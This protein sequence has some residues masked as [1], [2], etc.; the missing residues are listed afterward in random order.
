MR[1]E[2][3]LPYQ[4]SRLAS[5]KQRLARLIGVPG[6]LFAQPAQCLEDRERR[7]A[8]VARTRLGR[9]LRRES[10]SSPQ[11]RIDRTD[12]GRPRPAPLL[13]AEIDDAL[14]M[15]ADVPFEE[16]QERGWHVQPNSYLWP[17]NDVPFLRRNPELWAPPRIPRGIEWDLDGQ[18]DLLRHLSHYAD[19]LADVRDGPA[20]RPG[21]FVWENGAFGTGDALAYY[22][23]V[24]D[25]KPKRV[26]EIGAG[27]STLLLA[28]AWRRTAVMRR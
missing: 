20:H 21:E 2:R 7:A 25:L 23:L 3:S 26:I 8:R 28:R 17:L 18:L 11:I 14:A 27:A 6:D 16:L 9:L 19:E 10:G 1:A 12:E 5:H 22:G 13:G 4:L 24:R 15:L